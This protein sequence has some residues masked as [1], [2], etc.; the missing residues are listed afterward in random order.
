MTEQPASTRAPEQPHA[1]ASPRWARTEDVIWRRSIDQVVLLPSS[2]SA[3]VVLTGAGTR[4]WELL[5]EPR[6]LDTIVRVLADLYGA[7]PVEVER[8]VSAMFDELASIGVVRCQ[9]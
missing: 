4:V 5:D 6:A 9:R 3:A 7:A 1:A 8:D 2:A